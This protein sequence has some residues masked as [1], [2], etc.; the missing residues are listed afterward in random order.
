[1]SLL[2]R[3]LAAAGLAAAAVT[4]IAVLYACGGEPLPEAATPATTEPAPA[5]AGG[6]ACAK[7]TDCKG[8]RIC[9]KGQCTAPH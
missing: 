5:P 8:D 2:R 3:H 1:M 7:D 6:S 9:D 4:S